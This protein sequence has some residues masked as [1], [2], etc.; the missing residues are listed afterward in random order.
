M[1]ENGSNG[2]FDTPPIDQSRKFDVNGHVSV[3][4]KPKDDGRIPYN[5]H[6]D[7]EGNGIDSS[8]IF[9]TFD[10][11]HSYDRPSHR[12][13]PHVEAALRSN[14]KGLVDVG[15]AVFFAKQY[16]TL[17]EL[18]APKVATSS[19]AP[20]PEAPKMSVTA[21]RMLKVFPANEV[22]VRAPRPRAKVLAR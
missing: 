3:E 13:R 5:P 20:K 10:G 22:N 15:T 4:P 2:Y 11:R 9:G 17:E 7:F 19:E 6:R 12:I 14:A 18:N 8:K 21:S 1:S 16:R